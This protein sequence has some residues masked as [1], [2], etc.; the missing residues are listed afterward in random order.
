MRRLVFSS[1]L[2]KLWVEQ[3]GV[4]DIRRFM[5]EHRRLILFGGL[6]LLSLIACIRVGRKAHKG[7][8][9]FLRW[10]PFVASLHEGGPVYWRSATPE[11]LKVADEGEGF[12]NPPLLGV[13]LTPFYWP[14]DVAGT[15]L[16]SLTKCLC[17]AL[18][19]L[20][21]MRVLEARP[22]PGGLPDWVGLLLVLL[23]ARVFMGDLTHGNTNLLIG[24]LLA[25][26]LLCSFHRCDGWA[27]LLLG[28]AVVFKATPLLFVLYFVYKRRWRTVAFAIIGIGLF[29]FVLPGIALGF[30]RNL[31]LLRGWTD[32]MLLPVLEGGGAL[33]G[34]HLNQS[35]VGQVTRLF[36]DTVAVAPDRGRPA[37]YLN[38]LSL[39]PAAAGWITKGLAM[40]TLGVLGWLC[41]T[42][43]EDRAHPGH[44]AEFA[45]VFLAMVF[46]SPRSWKH[47]YVLLIL[48]HATLI[49]G[50]SGARAIRRRPVR[51]R[52]GRAL[53]LWRRHDRPPLEQRG[54][55]ARG[56]PRRRPVP[57]RRLRDDSQ[58]S[59]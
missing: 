20:G 3:A 33:A 1:I 59:V 56:L 5:D 46:V 29:L 32:Q 21:V 17:M 9:A 42:P 25:G 10:K 12:P 23:S 55:G 35:L 39:S 15:V 30:G 47:H 16:F 19:V 53:A 54:G 34:G 11:T 44:L 58:E 45:L 4:D 51:A 52:P 37:V 57:V 36:T 27:G 6:V 48:A 24:G 49:R 14:G 41:R 22:P 28:L 43:N 31:T 26:V 7:R 2:N 40:A 8:T 50:G 13:F 38:V 18:I